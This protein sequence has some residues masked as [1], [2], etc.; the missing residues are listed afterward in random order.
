TGQGRIQSL[1]LHATDRELAGRP[2][3]HRRRAG[4]RGLPTHLGRRRPRGHEANRRG[5]PVRPFSEDAPHPL[6]LSAMGGETMA[7]GPPAAPPGPRPGPDG[8]GRDPGRQ[9]SALMTGPIGSSCTGDTC[10]PSIRRRAHFI[11]PPCE[12]PTPRLLPYP[13]AYAG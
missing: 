12:R 4:G 6:E 11:D 2:T 1:L 10:R 5:L 8:D 3:G 13:G 7:Q 9:T